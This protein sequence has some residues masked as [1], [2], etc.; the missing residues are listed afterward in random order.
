MELVGAPGRPVSTS[1]LLLNP[2]IF[3]ATTPVTRRSCSR[4]CLGVALLASALAGCGGNGPPPA[5]FPSA[6][7]EDSGATAENENPLLQSD[8]DKPIILANVIQLIQTAPTNPGGNNFTLAAESLND[9]FLDTRPEAFAL[10]KEVR[11]FLMTQALP[12][13][14]LTTIENPKFTGQLDG[15][16]IED[17]L[18]YQSVAS[19]VAGDGD[20]LTRVGRVFDWVIRQVQ[21]VPPGSLAQPNMV[22][23]EGRPFQAQARPYDV[24]LRGMATEVPGG[25]A[26]RSW[27]FLSLCRQ[28]GIDAGLLAC[29]PPSGHRGVMFQNVPSAQEPVTMACGV[30]IDGQVYLFDAR[31]GMPI[32]GP[33]GQGIATVEQAAADPEILA[34]LNLPGRDYPVSRA[35]LVG[36]KIRVLLDATLGTLSPRMRL[37]Q[38]DLT[39]K[40]R[41]V[42]YRDPTEQSAAFQKALG[43]R[44]DRVQLW[45]LPLEV[46]WRLFHDGQFTQATLYPIQIFDPRWPLLSAR[47]DQLRG[48][49]DSAVQQFVSFRFAEGLVERDGKTPIPPQ[50]QHVLDMFATHYLALAQLDRGRLE[51]AR[52]LFGE[53]L[54]LLA[55]PGQ[56]QPYFNMYRWGACYNLG[57]LHEQEGNHPLAIRYLDQS[58]PTDQEHGNMLRVRELI[59]ADPFV[60][61]EGLPVPQEGPTPGQAAPLAGSTAQ[62]GP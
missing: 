43:P 27:L 26:E 2:R 9:Y 18:L 31:L 53:T 25:W 59:W 20:D 16:H 36:G 55:E 22:T 37:L 46:E 61:S 7:T 4:T 47:L 10:S 35:D 13:D 14:A 5:T 24:L 32:P 60:P 56:G 19:R 1:P 57:L 44:F 6:A 42:L 21:L 39:G 28:L 49:L 23:R 34:R 45:G 11:E 48:N 17:C 33:G 12:P 8:E 51:E 62:R 41:M 50:I 30:L 58:V 52:F 3:E 40:N 54:R 38:K 29:V 15:R